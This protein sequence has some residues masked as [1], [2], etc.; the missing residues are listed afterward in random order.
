[1]P[2]D[3]FA[4]YVRE[5]K[6]YRSLRDSVFSERFSSV[7]RESPL[8]AF[9]QFLMP[10]TRPDSVPPAN[11]GVILANFKQSVDVDSRRSVE[12]LSLET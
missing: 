11:A 2:I 7:N 1:M 9:A 4:P 5:G 12:R 8:S 6:E 3:L 10:E